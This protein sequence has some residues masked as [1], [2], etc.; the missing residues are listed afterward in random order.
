MYGHVVNFT[1]YKHVDFGIVC[2]LNNLL[3]YFDFDFFFCSGLVEGVFSIFR[4]DFCSL[5]NNH[6][7]SGVVVSGARLSD[8]QVGISMPDTGQFVQDSL[9]ALTLQFAFVLFIN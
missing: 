3:T 2:F 4:F 9:Y 8:N 5:K 1:S 7:C 6:Y